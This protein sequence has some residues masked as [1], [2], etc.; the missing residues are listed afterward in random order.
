MNEDEERLKS[1]IAAIPPET[2]SWP[3]AFYDV[4]ESESKDRMKI[5]L[6]EGADTL[7]MRKTWSKWI[8]GLI[9]G[10]V[11]FD[12]ILVIFYGLGILK[13]P[14]TT[15]V[16]AVITDNFLKIIGLGLLITSS[17]FERISRWK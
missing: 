6:Q 10:I 1:L 11:F 2:K 13:F 4:L 15:L 16:I 9:V 12:M 14:N 3:P 7:I 17:I 8:L 5:I